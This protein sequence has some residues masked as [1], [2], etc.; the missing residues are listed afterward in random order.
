MDRPVIHGSG[1]PRLCAYLPGDRGTV[2]HENRAWHDGHRPA[3]RTS[4]GCILGVPTGATLRVLLKLA[5]P[6]EIVVAVVLCGPS[7][8]GW[9]DFPWDS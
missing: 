4:V 2:S 8:L 1:E 7:S 5:S 9:V 6:L 3:T